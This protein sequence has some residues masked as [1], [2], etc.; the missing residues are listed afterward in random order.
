MIQPESADPDDAL[1]VAAQAKLRGELL[2]S[3]LADDVP[4]A[5]IESIIT[6]DDLAQTIGAQQKLLLDTVRS[7][8]SEGLMEFAGWGEVPLDKAMLRL[9]DLF[10]NHHDDPGSWAFAIWLTLTGAGK[11]LATQLQSQDAP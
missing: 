5:Q 6:R 2:V 4:L 7:L 8:V 11:H 9:Q 1:A 10:V 3:G